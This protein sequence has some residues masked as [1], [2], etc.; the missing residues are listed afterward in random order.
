MRIL[1][2]ILGFLATLFFFSWLLIFL[3][4]EENVPLRLFIA[5]STLVLFIHLYRNKKK[6]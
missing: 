5:I 6:K 1:Y 2:Y 3:E 4:V